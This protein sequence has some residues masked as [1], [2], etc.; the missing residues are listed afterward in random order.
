MFVQHVALT[1]SAGPALTQRLV[2]TRETYTSATQSP[3][4]ERI[5]AKRAV[6]RLDME[7]GA[8]VT[9]ADAARLASQRALL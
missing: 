2:S 7:V 3:D 5:L 8:D 4:V 6:A 9:G 1:H